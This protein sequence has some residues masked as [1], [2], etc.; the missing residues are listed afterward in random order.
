L[1]AN[2]EFGEWFRPDPEVLA[3]IETVED[4]DAVDCEISE[5]KAGWIAYEVEHA[6]QC[7]EKA[8]EF[9][10]LCYGRRGETFMEVSQYI[11]SAYGIQ[12]RTFQR[13][14]QGQILVPSSALTERVRQA[15]VCECE[16]LLEHLKQEVARLVEEDALS[17]EEI[18]VPEQIENLRARIGALRADPRTH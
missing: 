11:E 14:F 18:T 12:A 5:L 2:H 16:L 9:Y 6:A 7:V 8:R 1:R 17:G 3:F 13:L 15:P 10:A 4:G